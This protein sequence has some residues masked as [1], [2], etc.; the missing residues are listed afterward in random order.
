MTVKSSKGLCSPGQRN[1]RSH[2]FLFNRAADGL[3]K[4]ATEA[5]THQTLKD[6]HC[7][8]ANKTLSWVSSFLPLR[9]NDIMATWDM[10][11][12]DQKIPKNGTSCILDGLY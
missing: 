7:K 6:F 10:Y 9:G 8:K 1:G 12:L 11:S 4:C 2:D 5:S 3:S